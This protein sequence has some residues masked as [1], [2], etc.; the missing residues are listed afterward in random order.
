MPE[1]TK[2]QIEQMKK[3]F[4]SSDPC[5]VKIKYQGRVLE[6]WPHKK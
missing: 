6:K 1:P 5:E 2:E 4:K 3:S